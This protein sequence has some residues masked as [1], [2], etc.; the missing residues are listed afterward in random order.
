[1]RK[2]IC[3]G[4]IFIYCVIL[5]I[6]MGITPL[7]ILCLFLSLTLNT[8]CF[9]VPSPGVYIVYILEILAAWIQPEFLW[10]LPLLFFHAGLN[11]TERFEL[12]TNLTPVVRICLI[13]LAACLSILYHRS[14]FTLNTTPSYLFAILL[15]LCLAWLT[16]S[17]DR[18][19]HQFIHTMDE[20]TEQQ[21][22]LKEKNQALLAKQDAEVHAATLAERNRI[23]REIH[24]NV[25]HLL[26]RTL[27]MT[28]AIQ[29][30]NHTEELELPLIQLEDSLNQAMTSIREN[31]HNLH[32]EAVNLE[33][34]VIQL[35][36]DFQFCPV[37]LIYDIGYEPPVVIRYTFLAITKEALANIIR[38]S[39]AT[40]G[41]IIMR[42]HPCL[43][44]LEISDNGTNIDPSLSYPTGIGLTN[45]QER[46]SQLH[47]TLTLDT[48]HGFR[49]FI[50]IPKTP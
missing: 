2:I 11:L 4:I 47:G 34:A 14:L 16:S 25:G 39:N 24:D 5:R 35:V 27:L 37:R 28:G 10:F 21:I 29:T 6:T 13:C 8:L 46:V 30:M 42:E 41:K 1:M 9:L 20:H 31:V 26:S 40:K 44:Q 49:I 38:H 50:T 19:Y 7:F 36:Q 48:S 33:N 23:A 32:D 15:S 3:S 18:L 17:Y 22:L 12:N 43:Y 45:M